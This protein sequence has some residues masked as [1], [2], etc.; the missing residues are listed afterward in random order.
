MLPKKAGEASDVSAFVESKTVCADSERIDGGGVLLR[1]AASLSEGE[2]R[3]NAKRSVE[4]RWL[5]VEKKI[6]SVN[7]YATRLR[8]HISKEKK[9]DE[10]GKRGGEGGRVGEM[11]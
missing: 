4:R 3:A 7:I 5:V 10:D 8:C 9:D 1:D 11:E 6:T 2:G